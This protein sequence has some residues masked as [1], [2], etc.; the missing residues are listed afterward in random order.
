MPLIDGKRHPGNH[1]LHIRRPYVGNR[2]IGE[3]RLP[4]FSAIQSLILLTFERIEYPAFRDTD[5]TT[6]V[7]LMPNRREGP[8]TSLYYSSQG[9][10]N[11]VPF[12]F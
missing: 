12:D 8:N 10:V 9:V 7:Q 11:I 5:R 2:G 1:M 4:P 6:K 3:E